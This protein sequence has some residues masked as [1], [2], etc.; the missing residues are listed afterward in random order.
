MSFA[1]EGRPPVPG[2][3]IEEADPNL[4]DAPRYTC[5]LVGEC[6]I[7]CN[8]GA[9]NTLDFNYLSAAKRA[10]AELR[11]GAEVRSLE[12]RDDHA[13]NHHDQ[14]QQ[15]L[16]HGGQPRSVRPFRVGWR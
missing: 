9:K 11:T 13:E 6:D 8:L 10:G 3:R 14:E 7:G 5:R 16:L 2:E 12:P 1:N 4:H 15:Q